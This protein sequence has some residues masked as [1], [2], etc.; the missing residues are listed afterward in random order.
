MD[1]E[2]VKSIEIDK[3]EDL[4]LVFDEE[5]E[6]V[7]M[8]FEEE[9]EEDVDD[10]DEE[11]EE[12]EKMQLPMVSSW[13]DAHT[14][15]TVHGVEVMIMEEELGCLPCGHIFGMSCIHEWLL[16]RCSG[17]C[18]QC[19][20]SFTLKS[21]WL[22]Y[23]TRIR[24]PADDDQKASTRRFPYSKQGFTAFK[25]YQR[26]RL[27]HAINSRSDALRR[28]AD[29]L[30]RQTYAMNRRA[31]LLNRRDNAEKRAKA[32]ERRVDAL[33][34]ADAWRRWA[35]TLGRRADTL[36]RQADG[37][38]RKADEFGR[39]AKALR[40][41]ANKAT[42]SF[43]GW[44]DTRTLRDSLLVTKTNGKQQSLFLP[45]H[46]GRKPLSDSDR[47]MKSKATSFLEDV[48]EVWPVHSCCVIFDLEPLSLSFDFVFSSEIFKYGR[49]WLC[50]S[51][52][53]GCDNLQFREDRPVIR[54][55]QS[56]H[57]S[58]SESDSY[59]LSD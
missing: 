38:L 7:N 17:K 56:R 11:I 5:E 47:A 46:A 28:R 41:R 55:S 2:D 16:N 42:R 48:W 40:R 13:I 8:E 59:Y 36:G 18:P 12:V 44:H 10:G 33:G 1:K 6:E 30:R 58:K 23:A 39:Q 4:E 26:G 22:L 43:M 9:K 45:N 27:T 35:D 29:V 24:I 14:C 37:Y 32:L 31:E 15:K 19:N 52:D 57:H 20:T 21:V 25:Q 50:H 53:Y 3:E 34:R 51:S 54:T 49:I